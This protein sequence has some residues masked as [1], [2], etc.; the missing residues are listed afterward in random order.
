[1]RNLFSTRI[2]LRLDESDQVDMVL[3][4]GGRR[5]LVSRRSG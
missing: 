3:G 5:V 1:L 4:Y 2:G